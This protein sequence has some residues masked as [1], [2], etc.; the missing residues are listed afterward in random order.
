M[1]IKRVTNL[2]EHI[3]KTELARR[4]AQESEFAP[5]N[6]DNDWSRQIDMTER[7]ENFCNGWDGAS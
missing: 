1:P 7:L 3:I 2:P 5:N 4:F 6:C